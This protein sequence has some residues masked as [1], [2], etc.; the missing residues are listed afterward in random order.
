MLSVFTAEDDL[1]QE[2]YMSWKVVMMK[3]LFAALIILPL[4]PSVRAQHVAFSGCMENGHIVWYDHPVTTCGS[5]APST[6]SSAVD[7]LS[8]VMQQAITTYL[9]VLGSI[10]QQAQQRK[11]FLEEAERR[12][13]EAEQQRILEEQRRRDEIFR[14]LSGELK[15]DGLP[16][17][18]LKGME[19]SPALKLKG[20]EETTR[21]SG[22]LKLKLGG[23]DGTKP[24]GIPGLPG[25]YTGGARAASANSP[26]AGGSQ[27]SSLNNKDELHLKLGDEATK[28]APNQGTDKVAQP[29]G[30]PAQVGGGVGIP[31][32]P[33]VYLDGAN[34]GDATKLA[35]AAQKLSGPDREVAEETALDAASRNPALT[36]PSQDPSVNSFQ[37]ARSDYEQA[38]QAQASAADVYKSAQTRHDANQSVLD[39]ARSEVEKGDPA[40]AAPTVAAK[41]EALANLVAGAKSDEEAWERAKQ[42]F[43]TATTNLGYSR[44][45]AVDALAAMAS[46]TGTPVVDLRDAREPLIINPQDLRPPTREGGPITEVKGGPTPEVTIPRTA[47][48]LRAEISGI[49]QALKRLSQSQK[50]EAA[51]RAAWEKATDDA[52][53]DAWSR[54]IDMATE[55]VTSKLHSVVDKHMKTLEQEMQYTVLLRASNEADATKRA[56][57]DGQ[58]KKLLEDKESLETAMKRFEWVKQHGDEF[59]SALKVGIW[60]KEKPEDL[61]GTLEGV[62]QLMDNL[63]KDPGVQKAL[64]L[65]P[66]GTGVITYASSI[67]DSSYDIA[68][69]VIGIKRLGQLNQ[70]SDEY[71]VAVTQ[72]QEKMKATVQQLKLLEG[73]N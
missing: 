5:S 54:G 65:T 44:T 42:G 2:N 43:D 15:L 55:G 66:A 68:T 4:V 52:T 37:E 51:E 35:A 12:R 6:S 45:K 47:Q 22:E 25:T 10:R 56:V 69:E 58:F 14:R 26:D 19:S 40:S 72:L 59:N 38:R 17:L 67:L 1:T 8:P 16:G 34:Q 64:Q 50:M 46:G 7:T 30:G 13:V 57:L 9:S 33:G 23:D 63:L 49:Q 70:N 36:A 3:F 60:A 73:Q 62:R 21:G 71:R 18:H 48:Q 27:E 20:L 41:Q 24:Y 61:E 53:L 28:P 31:G 32:L 29:T 39:L 11:A